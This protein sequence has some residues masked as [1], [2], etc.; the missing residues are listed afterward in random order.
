M[1]VLNKYSPLKRKYIKA[2]YAEYMDKELT[3]VKMKRSRLWNVYLK[4]RSKENRSA[5]KKEHTFCVT[6]LRKKKPDHF[7]NLR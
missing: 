7:N 5:Y 4:H 3:Q 6:L 1:D 2:S